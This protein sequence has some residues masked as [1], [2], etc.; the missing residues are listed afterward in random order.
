MGCGFWPLGPA[1]VEEEVEVV[2]ADMTVN[3]GF[4]GSQKGNLGYE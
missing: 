3:E 2:G 1:N 4:A